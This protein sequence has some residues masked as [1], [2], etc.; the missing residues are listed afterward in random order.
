VGTD[1]AGNIK[2][3]TDLIARA[4]AHGLLI[5]T[6]TFRND[7]F[8]VAYTGGPIE[9]YLQFYRLGIDGVFSDFPGTAWAAREIFRGP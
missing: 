8:P 6:W 3:V 1:P 7:A 2:K 9:E 4:H 5:H